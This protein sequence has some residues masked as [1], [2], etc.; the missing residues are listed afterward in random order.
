MQ[1]VVEYAPMM[2]IKYNPSPDIAVFLT[3][4]DQLEFGSSKLQ[5]LFCPGHSPGSICFYSEED[6]FLIG[7]DV[8]FQM[9]IGRTDLPGG[10][11][12]TLIKSIKKK[13][14][15]L[16][17]DTIVYP[18]HGPATSIAFEKRNNPFLNS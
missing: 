10:D 9:S 14:L 5:I 13:V 6:K 8:L 2:G 17:E 1:S 16:P 15:K 7:G 4:E 18:G 3:E 12:D 11:H